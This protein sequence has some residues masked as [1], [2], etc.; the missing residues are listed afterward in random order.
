MIVEVFVTVLFLIC[1]F[2]GWVTRRVFQDGLSSTSQR[3]AQVALVWLVPAV[4]A[5]VVLTS[6]AG[7]A[8]KAQGATAIHP[9]PEMTSATHVWSLET[10]A[11]QTRSSASSSELDK[12]A[13]SSLNVCSQVLW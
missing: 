4:G 9:I 10:Q 2:N 12:I 8:R 13:R 1:I 6:S 7:T 11:S 5:L 3:I